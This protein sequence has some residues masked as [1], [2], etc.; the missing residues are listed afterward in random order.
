MQVIVADNEYLLVCSFTRQTVLKTHAVDQYSFAC[1]LRQLL[2]TLQVRQSRAVHMRY[3][4]QLFSLGNSVFIH[5][6][7]T[8][9]VGLTGSNL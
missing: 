1:R 7:C 2:H 6:G 8:P 9:F 5:C 4:L 3:M